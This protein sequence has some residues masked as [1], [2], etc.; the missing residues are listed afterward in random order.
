MKKVVW[1]E[2]VVEGGRLVERLLPPVPDVAGPY[3]DC[4]R[5]GAD[6]E[7]YRYARSWV[8]LAVPAERWQEVRQPSSASI[9]D[10]LPRDPTG[11]STASIEQVFDEPVRVAAVTVGLPG[12]RGFGAAPGPEAVLEASDDGREYRRVAQLP[13]TNVPVRTVA[14][15]PVTARRFRL[16]L[17]ADGAAAALPQLA[18]GV[19]LPPV[20]RPM[21]EFLISQFALWPGGRVSHAEV[22]AGFGVTPDY[23]EL[24]DGPDA[25]NALDP[26]RTLD[27]SAHVDEAGLL[28][29]SAPPGRWRILRFGASL[30]GQT[31]GPAPA[32]ATG[33]EV[34]KLDAD[35]VRRYLDTYLSYFDPLDLQALLSDSIESG[36][37]NWTDRLLDRFREVRGYDAR[38]WLP[39]LAGY[40]V[41]DRAATDAFLWDYRR[42]ITDLLASEYYATIAAVA[43]SRGLNYYAEALEDHRPQLGDDL[44]MRAAAD[45]PMGAMWTFDADNCAKPTYVADLKGASSVAH[46]YGKLYTGAESMSAFH[47]PWSDTPQRLKHVADLELAL[48]V[49]RF[50][51]HTSPHQPVAVPPP[52]IGLSPYLGQTFIRTETWADFAGPWVDYLARCSYL[53]NAG[54]PA[55]DI[56]YFIGEEAPVTALFGDQ[57]ET[58][59][60]YGYDYDFVN[61][62]A[63]EER[64]SV[65][66]GALVAG[67]TRYRLLY[68]GGS[69]RWMTVRALRRL[70]QLAADGA[71]VVGRRPA[72]SPS[73]SDDPGEHDRLCE[74]LW[75]A[76]RV[77]DTNDLRAVLRDLGVA[78]LL[79]V[80]G[81]QPPMIGRRLGEHRLV[82]LTNPSTKPLTVVVSDADA[83][84]AAWDPVELHRWALPETEGGYTLT[85]PPLGSMF[86]LPDDAPSRRDSYHLVELA[87]EWQLTLPGAGSVSWSGSARPWSDLAYAGVGMYRTEVTVDM[88]PS[89]AGRLYL[90]LAGVGDIARVRVNGHDCG[91]AWT[92]P[93]RVEVTAALHSGRNGIEVEV[94]NSWMNRLIAEAGTPSGEL[95]P[96]VTSVYAPDARPRPAGLLGP[97]TLR[98]EPR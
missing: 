75:G 60:P 83:R 54:S 57:L 34:D 62:D 4:P 35:K 89:G 10:P 25:D 32:D 43:N 91:I 29:W 45:V 16:V 41:R 20:L 77:M 85:L 86:V 80:E 17:S 11:F 50:C 9:G 33:L 65:E 18:P 76:G 78:P 27:V 84:L 82:F 15:E 72:G 26:D 64:F 73:L 24:R 69:S 61:V 3:Q 30:T 22:K 14:F 97:V 38:P 1:S 28:Y 2:T 67:A 63:L 36:P 58:A 92:E 39:A 40:L 71:A 79:S 46:V 70:V 96:P 5:W 31:N 51:I 44:A 19:T 59:V 49:T 52:G 23:Y 74:M 13:V 55:T 53:L 42:T 37:Q 48:G 94:A 87:G 8:V 81:G 66:N 6:P 56:A 88:L 12:P 47:R 98:W 68:L 21:S 90:A 95:F 7:Q 93:F